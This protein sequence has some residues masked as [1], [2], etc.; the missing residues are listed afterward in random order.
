[1]TELPVY[2]L[3]IN[4]KT[5]L[6]SAYM[7]FVRNGGIYLKGV[8]HAAGH[9]VG[10]LLSIPNEH[11]VYAITCKVVWVTPKTQ[12]SEG[13][14]GVQFPENSDCIQLKNKIDTLLGGMDRTKQPT[15]TA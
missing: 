2:N 15:M 7:P 5:A 14:I 3:I 1:M 11:H 4:D 13:G 10:L 8:Q 12:M 9:D 6:L